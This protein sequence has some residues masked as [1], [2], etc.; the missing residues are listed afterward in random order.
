[1]AQTADH[2]I[3]IGRGRLIKDSS[4]REMLEGTVERR[5]LVRATDPGRLAD[6]LAA[7]GVSVTRTPDGTLEVTGMDAAAVSGAAAAQGVLLHELS[8]QTASLEDAYMSLTRS[9]LEF[10]STGEH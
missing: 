9:A 1:M 2:L 10:S 3:V 5:V 8:T 6:A 4:L 7:P